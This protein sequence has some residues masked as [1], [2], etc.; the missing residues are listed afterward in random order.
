MKEQLVSEAAYC[1][2]A[3]YVEKTVIAA[4][5]LKGV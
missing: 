5:G 4:G 3:N 2:R 1:N